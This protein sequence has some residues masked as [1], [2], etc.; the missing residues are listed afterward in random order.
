MDIDDVR[1][2]VDHLGK[3]RRGEKDV[4]TDHIEKGERAAGPE[5]SSQEAHAG[6]ATSTRTLFAWC[7]RVERAVACHGPV[8]TRAD[9]G[10]QRA[11]RRACWR[12]FRDPTCART[13]GTCDAAS[14][15]P[16]RAASDAADLLRCCRFGRD[17]GAERVARGEGTAERPV[18]SRAA[19]RLRLGLGSG[20]RCRSTVAAWASNRFNT[21]PKSS[22]FSTVRA[23][24]LAEVSPGRRAFARA[25]R[26]CRL[27]RLENLLLRPRA[28]AIL[29]SKSFGVSDLSAWALAAATK[30]S[31]C[32]V[33]SSRALLK[34]SVMQRWSAGHVPERLSHSPPGEY[35]SS[36]P[37]GA[38]WIP[39]AGALP[40]GRWLP[41][42][43]R[44]RATSRVA[45]L[46]PRRP[47]RCT[48]G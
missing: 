18:P 12:R 21:S 36:S 23:F 1:L 31:S 14:L 4:D 30:A 22:A 35:K 29:A 44:H 41:S 48:N 17:A 19:E 24:P 2:P 15:R 40:T 33:Q 46:S 16:L 26:A 20:A 6:T 37:P 10:R 27:A 45:P 47:G 34:S 25:L 28:R 43:G 5:R 38:R 13:R 3:E 11:S 32:W 7:L 8:S 9:L 39:V 42:A